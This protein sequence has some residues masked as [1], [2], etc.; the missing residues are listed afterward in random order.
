[1]SLPGIP[2]SWTLLDSPAGLRVLRGKKAAPAQVSRA[3]A[4]DLLLLEVLDQVLGVDELSLQPPLV[5]QQWVQL[6]P[7]VVDVGLEKWLQVVP[8]CFH[9]LLLQQTPLGF[10]HFVLL[11]KESDLEGE[12]ILKGLG[13]NRDWGEFPCKWEGLRTGWEGEMLL[14]ADFQSQ[15]L[16]CWEIWLQGPCSVLQTLEQPLIFW[17]PIRCLNCEQVQ[18]FCGKKV[19][20]WDKEQSRACSLIKIR[21]LRCCFSFPSVELP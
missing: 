15:I 18:G 20:K 21:L 1:M 11:L 12:I 6:H 17:L 2:G 19:S 10:Q 7:Q 13:K 4:Q 14:S 16:I 9:S 8:H 5:A 3:L